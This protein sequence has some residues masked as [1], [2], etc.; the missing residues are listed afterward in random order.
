[1]ACEVKILTTVYNTETQQMESQP[2]TIGIVDETETVTMD[3]V[4]ELLST[5][6]PSDRKSLASS[7]VRAKRQTITAKMIGEH[8]FVG[9]TTV[10]EILS[11]YPQLAEVYK[12]NPKLYDSYTII[13][14]SNF[15]LNNVNYNG[16]VLTADGR[17][18]FII[19]DIYG[20]TAFIKYLQAKERAE[21]IFENEDSMPEALLPYIEDL[22]VIAKRYGK[23]VKDTVIEYLN[24]KDALKPFV[25]K[26]NT[27]TPRQILG[28][29]VA[30]LTN[31]YNFDENM[32]DLEIG[33]S[34][35]KSEDTGYDWK[36]PKSELYTILTT[37]FP[38]LG[39]QLSLENFRNLT[40][41]ELDNL[42]TGPNGL[43]VGHPK[44]GRAKIKSSTRGSQKVIQPKEATTKKVGKLTHEYLKAA[45]DEVRS[46]AS[47]AGIELPAK[48]SEYAKENPESMANI[49]N[50]ANF[51]Y[52]DS[53]TGQTHT[54]HA[55]VVEDKAGR[56]KV[57]YSY[58]YEV[59]N[60]PKIQESASYITL[61]FPYSTMGEVYNFG[62]NS[63]SIFSPVDEGEVVAGKYKGMYMYKASIPTVR[64]NRTVYA[65]SR[66]II[67][68]NSYMSTY[69]SLEAAMEG[70]N[71]K[72]ATDRIGANSLITI[73]QTGDIPRQC[74]IELDSIQ[75]GQ[76]ITTLAIDLPKIQIEKLPNSLKQMLS[77]TVPEFQQFLSTIPNITKLDTPEKA[78]AF[79]L[80]VSDKFSRADSREIDKAKTMNT[81]TELLKS[82]TYAEVI[83][84]IIRT[85][86]T[87]LTRSYYVE[88]LVISKETEHRA[89][90][91]IATLKLL[92]DGG[93][94]VD[95]SGSKVG[96]ISIDEFIGQTM[97]GAIEFFN[98]QYGVDVVSM[99]SDELLVFSQENNL[100]LENN[101][102]GIKA[103]IY[104]NRIYINTT[105]AK[106]SDL[107]HEISHI[108]LGVLKARYPEGYQQI[109]QEYQRKSGY[110]R[111]FDWI[112]SAYSNFAMQDKVEEA[113]VDMI[114]DEMFRDNKLSVG[115]NADR[116]TEIMQ[117]IIN[118]VDSFKQDMMDNGLG[119]NDF[120]KTLMDAESDK[121]RRQRIVTNFIH[122]KLGNEI[123]EDCK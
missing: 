38:E 22:K 101:I 52:T 23:S 58:E 73:K 85:I 107:F 9:N 95:V 2:V 5:L 29:V 104:N 36:L 56:K 120:M 37:Y 54:I 64:G 110:K 102:D 99:T 28:R 97:D 17:E 68:P 59:V 10:G 98:R 12:I 3:R 33:I 115:F 81:L 123:V 41:K 89:K 15:K 75:D 119:F 13:R 26:A 91:K 20:A 65:I 100:G 106:T 71:R 109:I 19:K 46:Q 83:D 8:Q 78:A 51:Q 44:L 87:A 113:I 4:V 70:I 47:A 63:Q 116:F 108:F 79:L 14:S 76:I 40:N 55:R 24:N 93:N 49:F 21:A 82:G 42:F 69:P 1:M 121:M 31:D 34:S 80:L 122:S 61:T 86:D 48:Y 90:R 53:K 18:M 6:S 32:T 62:Y 111:K 45:W 60:E 117:D 16:R 114:A 11:K 25:Y 112:S 88:K 27:I 57:E 7:I 118:K 74:N 72:A 105:N 84:N 67:S 50:S 30:T 35:I 39:E 96:D 103:F 43:F 77:L 94:S 92:E 66:S